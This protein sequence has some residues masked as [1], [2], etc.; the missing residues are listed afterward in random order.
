MKLADV[1]QYLEATLSTA[2]SLVA[3]GGAPLEDYAAIGEHLADQV[4]E[5]HEHLRQGG[6][7]PARWTSRADGGVRS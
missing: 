3:N 2:R 7:L 4:L 1:D 5:L 6:P